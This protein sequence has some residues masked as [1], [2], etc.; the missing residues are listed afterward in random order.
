MWGD[1]EDLQK[2][3]QEWL[4]LKCQMKFTV[5]NWQKM[6]MGNNNSDFI[7]ELI[8]TIWEQ[9]FALQQLVPWKCPV[10][11][12]QS[13]NKKDVV[14][15]ESVVHYC[16]KYKNQVTSSEACRSQGSMQ[17]QVRWFFVPLV[18]ELR[19]TLPGD[20]VGAG[21]T[22]RLKGRADVFIEEQS[23]ASYW[24][25]EL[26]MASQLPD[27]EMVGH[28]EKFKDVCIFFLFSYSTPLACGFD[29]SRGEELA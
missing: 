20:I 18:F 13:I 8:V 11:I 24:A 25:T 12:Y 10:N 17:K 14:K 26:N 28:G 16:F 21:G 29:V 27:L 5:S 15:R 7:S 23:I 4:P 9:Q 19:D 1:M 6:H 22:H 2:T 3:L